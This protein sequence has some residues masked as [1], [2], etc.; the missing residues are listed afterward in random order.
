MSGTIEATAPAQETPPFQIGRTFISP[1]FDYLLIGGGMSLLMIVF[2][3]ALERFGNIGLLR[4]DTQTIAAIILLSNS[5]HFAASTVRLYTKPG[6]FRDLPFLTMGFPLVTI[7]VLTLS[8]WFYDIIGRH[9]NALYLT[10]SP[11]HYAAQAYGLAVMYCYR[12]GANLSLSDKR[13]MRWTCMLPFFWAFMRGGNSGLGWFISPDFQAAHLPLTN[14]ITV[15][16]KILAALTF[17][18]PAAL[19]FRLRSRSGLTMPLISLLLI[20]SNGLWWISFSYVNAFVWATVFHGIQYIAIVTIFHVKD[21]A[22]RD[23]DAH[24]WAYHSLKFYGMCVIL[25]YL[26]F[27]VWPHAY[28]LAGFGWSDSLLLVAAVINIHHFIVDGY[29]WKLRKDPNYRVVTDGVGV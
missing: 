28:A 22:G 10:W 12:S 6:A 19:Y 18:S 29:I 16:Q 14:A 20:L 15:I 4:V 26:L 2:L 24:G 5:A 23:G 27:S 11:Y 25:G 9:L 13:L 7:A 3:G 17:A 8:I 1:A 21:H